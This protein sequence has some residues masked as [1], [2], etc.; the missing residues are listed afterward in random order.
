MGGLDEQH[1]ARNSQGRDVGSD[2]ESEAWI[3]DEEG[4]IDVRHGAH[5][6]QQAL[7]VKNYNEGYP[8]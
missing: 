3:A 5:G 1:A 7:S 2:P 4:S 8:S 6:M